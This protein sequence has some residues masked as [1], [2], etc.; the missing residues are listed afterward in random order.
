MK[1]TKTKTKTASKTKKKPTAAK[2]AALKKKPPLKTP[3]KA[4]K[5]TS[6][7]VP[8]KKAAVGKKAA[9]KKAI[10][11]KKVAP[12]KALGL[13]EQMRDAVLKVLDERQGED[14]VA[15]DL[16]GRSALADYAIV[17]SGRSGRQLAAIA[18]YI[19]EAFFKLGVRRIRVEGVGQGDWVLI[20]GGDV[21]IHLFRPEVRSYYHI[22]EIWSA[23]SPTR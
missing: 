6:K 16:R 13:P 7:A 1:A 3:K 18:E 4:T 11:K 21:I 15:V 10:S 12:K 19:R 9:P 14:I 2:Q 17:A 20:D 23:K 5:V 8:K 22:E